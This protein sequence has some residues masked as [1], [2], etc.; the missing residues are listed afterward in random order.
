MAV[1]DGRATIDVA[2]THKHGALDLKK[3]REWRAL[4][5]RTRSNGNGK[6]QMHATM[7]TVVKEIFE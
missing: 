3:E 6:L 5:S 1:L 7:Q 2:T 4:F